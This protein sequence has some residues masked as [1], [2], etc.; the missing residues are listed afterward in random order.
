MADKISQ[1]DVAI[2]KE[3]EAVS[4]NLKK[5]TETMMGNFS[6]MVSE[7]TK[8]TD[9]E[10]KRISLSEKSAEM[11][12]HEAALYETLGQ[13]SSDMQIRADYMADAAQRRVDIHQQ[14]LANMNEQ[15]EALRAQGAE[16]DNMQM[17]LMD[18]IEAQKKS[19]QVEQK[20][21]IHLNAAKSVNKDIAGGL[22][23]MAGLS[24]ELSLSGKL[25]SAAAN[26]ASLKDVLGG[27]VDQLKEANAGTFALD[28]ASKKLTQ[29]MVALGTMAV[30]QALSLDKSQSEI[31][32][33]TGGLG[34]FDSAVEDAYQSNKAFG[35]TVEDASGAVKDLFQ[36]TS[37]FSMM[38]KAQQSDLTTTAAL[39][40]QAGVSSAAF[41]GGLEVSM[42]ALGKTAEEARDTQTDLLRFSQELGMSPQLMAENFKDAGPILAKFSHNAERNFKDVAKAAKATGMEIS[43]I[44]DFTQ[45]FDTF[46]GAADKVGSLNAMLGGDFVNAMDLMAAEN[47][48]ERMKM[49]TD[50]VKDAGKSFEDMTYYEKLAIAE[51][52]GF[53][54]VQELSKA[55]SGDMDTLSM[56]T[57]ERAMKEA[58]LAKVTAANQDIQAQFAAAIAAMA[59]DIKR[60]I[61]FLSELAQDVLPVL[62][63]HGGKVIFVLGAFKAITMAAQ[64]ATALQTLGLATNTT[65]LGTN[66][67]AGLKNV[68][69]VGLSIIQYG[70]MAAGYVLYA[71]A[72]ATV[73]L[74]KYALVAAAK[75]LA[76]VMAA[77]PIGLAVV[78]IVAVGAAIYAL[79]NGWEKTVDMMKTIGIRLFQVITFPMRAAVASVIGGFNLIIKG[80]NKIPG[81][82]IPIIPNLSGVMAA[83]IPGLKNGANSYGGVALVGEEGPEMVA[84]PPRSS[85]APAKTTSPA[86]ETVRA[87]TAGG[88]GSVAMGAASTGGGSDRPI[89]LNVVLE[90]DNRKVGEFVKTVMQKEMNP[91]SG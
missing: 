38:S 78:G 70:A 65:A 59:P 55:L 53:A 58:E 57:E 16:T 86:V 14:T 49:I 47:P 54:D 83:G 75:L 13:R 2:V 24:D 17:L 18:A 61:D 30:E 46:E 72:L 37:Q 23:K 28:A 71:G 60:F 85:V 63:K 62:A 82:N 7:S 36:S 74:A 22:M 31:D 4:E 52:G 67:L 21:L 48:A 9:E 56:S 69:M 51:A 79:V 81:V 11:L 76:L 8:L 41:A 6:K 40:N 12:E 26:G 20:R 77:N 5:L 3:L 68:A 84:M 64:F 90:L 42:K 35:V 29:G 88:A 73:T 33:L 87:L 89:N 66:T 43:R 44:L 10:K 27:V 91:S 19:V 32:K 39:M 50:A 80:I 15:L 25:M 45:Q 1:N 34:K